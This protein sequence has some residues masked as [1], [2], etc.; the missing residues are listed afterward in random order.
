MQHIH[1]MG[2]HGA[3]HGE[4]DD[5]MDSPP[6]YDRYDDEGVRVPDPVRLQRLVNTRSTSDN[7]DEMAAFARAEDP[8]VEWL[9][10][11]P[12]HLSSMLSLDKTREQ[13]SKEKRWLLVNLQSHDEF[14]SHLLNRD[15]W[16]DE[17]IESLLRGDYLFWQRGHTS[18]QGRDYMR[19][20][21]TIDDQLPLIAILHPTTGAVKFTWTVI[22]SPSV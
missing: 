20:Y 3:D 9:F 16:A 2:G 21:R 11:P 6:R 14:T 13:A 5:E 7:M 18:V 15:V 19:L 1:R 10:A 8:G 4:E 12:R 22:R 17:T